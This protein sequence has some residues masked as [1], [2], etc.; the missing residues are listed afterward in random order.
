MEKQQRKE[1]K[2][3]DEETK[4]A[5]IDHYFQHFGVLPSS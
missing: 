3:Q 2:K 1:K 5:L 4:D